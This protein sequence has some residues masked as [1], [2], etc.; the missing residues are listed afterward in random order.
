MKGL[1]IKDI[2]VLSKQLRIIG[3]LLLFYF[4]MGVAVGTSMISAFSFGILLCSIMIVVSSFAYD[5]QAKWT[6]YCRALPISANKVVLS[7]YLLV[8]MFTALGIV[9]ALILQVFTAVV[10]KQPANIMENLV[11]LLTFCLAALLLTS[12]LIPFVVWLGAEKARVIMMA[13]IMLPTI[14]IMLFSDDIDTLLPLLSEPGV[15]LKLLAVNVTVVMVF[16]YFISVVI[17]K[18]K[19]R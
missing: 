16:S 4:V 6:D 17:Y 9:V 2:L 13:I 15:L 10:A 5:D 8:L 1:F 19:G 12:I 7:K 11:S 14:G 18:K 3:I